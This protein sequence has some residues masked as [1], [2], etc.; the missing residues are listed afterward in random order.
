MGGSG[1][2]AGRGASAPA[3]PT[4]A[5][6]EPL[7][8]KAWETMR[9]GFR[10]S[11]PSAGCRTRSNQGVALSTMIN[12]FVSLAAIVAILV[13]QASTPTRA[14]YST[15]LYVPHAVRFQNP[16]ETACTAD[17]TLIMLNL[18]SLNSSYQWTTAAPDAAPAPTFVWKPTLSFKAQESILSWERAHQDEPLYK[19]GADVA[20]WRNALNYYGWGSITAGVYQDLAYTTF[21]QAA[22]ATVRSIAMTDMPVGILAWYGSHAQIVTGYS[23]TG[24]DPRTGST[25]F[26]INGVF[27]TDPLM[28]RHH[29]DYYVTYEEWKAG[30]IQLRFG[31]YLQVNSIYKDPIDGKAGKRVWLHKFVIIGPA[32]LG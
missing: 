24:D 31:P 3:V 30:P 20:G 15:N 23:V 14:T 11:S 13:G 29:L 17:A 6:A 26:K 7:L 9:P 21:A 1:T 25:N 19:P 5:L 16:D 32:S 28:E 10:R 4:I 18:I 27:L 12:V 8:A 2:T 22:V